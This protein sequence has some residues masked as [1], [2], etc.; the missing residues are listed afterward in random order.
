MKRKQELL[1]S[2]LKEV[3]NQKVDMLNE[4]KKGYDGLERPDFLWHFLLQSFST[5]GR[6]SGWDGLIG[7]KT[8][9][10]QVT[11]QEL[12]SLPEKEREEQVI[13]VCR[14]A[15]IRMPDQKAEYILKCFKQV[16]ELGGPEAA[17]E[18][19]LSL[20]GRDLKIKFLRQFHGIGQK[21]A[22]NIMMD[23]YHEDFRNSI[24]IDVRIK[25]ISTL[26]DIDFKTY[27]EE[28]IF[29][30]ESAKKAGLNGWEVDRLLY[31]FRST[32]ENLLKNVV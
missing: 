29:Y 26:L 2:A 20:K 32:F 19:L 3:A 11:F 22:R 27:E 23:V 25:A 12:D 30:L 21:Y 10:N 1:V 16:K 7:N 6:S 24:A 13:A 31:N 9:Y 5:M 14:K 15:K 18:S 17:K 4:H 8:N 28:E